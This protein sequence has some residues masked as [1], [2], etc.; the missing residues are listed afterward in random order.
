MSSRIQFQKHALPALLADITHSFEPL[1]KNP[2]FN[3]EFFIWITTHSIYSQVS[4][5]DPC[6]LNVKSWKHTFSKWLLDVEFEKQ[7]CHFLFLRF[8]P[9]NYDG[10]LGISIYGRKHVYCRRGIIN[11]ASKS[12]IKQTIFKSTKLLI[13]IAFYSFYDGR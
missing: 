7:C 9:Q 11:G 4:Y 10:R 6:A 8:L 12:K 2:G 1:T 3:L 5:A 13:F